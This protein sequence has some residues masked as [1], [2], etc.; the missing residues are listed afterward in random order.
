MLCQLRGGEVAL[1]E[2]IPSVRCFI[3]VL[4][5]RAHAS[6]GWQ[7]DDVM[8]C[9]LGQQRAVINTLGDLLKES[10]RVIDVTWLG[11]ALGGRG[12]RNA[13]CQPVG[14]ERRRTS[15]QEMNALRA[16]GML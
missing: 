16:C 1:T 8:L 4:R 3:A 6:H 12:G 2:N 5:G 15:P 14:S 7:A 11:S 13:P 9:Q 10:P